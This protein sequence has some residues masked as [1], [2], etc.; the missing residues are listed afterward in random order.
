MA[1]VS[2]IVPGGFGYG[3]APPLHPEIA[4]DAGQYLDVSPAEKR[5]FE[6]STAYGIKLDARIVTYPE[7]APTLELETVLQ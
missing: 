2:R 5:L 7:L 1:T 4:A 6:L 3:V